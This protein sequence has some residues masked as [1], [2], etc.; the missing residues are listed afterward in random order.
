MHFRSLST[1]TLGTRFSQIWLLYSCV[2]DT[3]SV[4]MWDQQ[5]VKTSTRLTPVWDIGRNISSP[6]ADSR[7][8]G[9]EKRWKGQ[10]GEKQKVISS[11]EREKCNRRGYMMR[12]VERKWEQSREGKWSAEERS[13]GCTERLSQL[14]NAFCGIQQVC[15]FHRSGWPRERE[16]HMETP[17][18][19]YVCPKKATA[20][21]Q[22]CQY[23]KLSQWW[24]TCTFITFLYLWLS[25]T[26]SDI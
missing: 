20:K 10:L 1:E 14:T 23:D 16:R 2:A 22:L 18:V 15:C 12:G 26:F 21:V 3:F 25:C 19:N 13:R 17:M 5:S 8:T 11:V 4:V 9:L 6:R 24:R 7:T